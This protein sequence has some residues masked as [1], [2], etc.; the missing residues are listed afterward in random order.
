VADERPGGARSERRPHREIGTGYVDRIYVLVPDDEGRFQIATGGVY[1]YYEFLQPVAERLDDET[2]RQM[3][4]DE[5][6][7][8]RPAWEAPI[9][10]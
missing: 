7:P 3:L 9:F 6:A 1:S 8:D 4:A 2:W 5:E 10:G